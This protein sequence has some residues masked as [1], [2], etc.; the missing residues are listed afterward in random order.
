MKL[1]LALLLLGSSTL[2]ADTQTLSVSYR[3]HAYRFSMV[4]AKVELISDLVK[5]RL[6]LGTCPVRK[7]FAD[8]WK[9]FEEREQAV[10]LLDLPRERDEIVAYDNKKKKGKVLPETDLGRML[11]ELPS[12]FHALAIVARMSCKRI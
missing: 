5:E 7:D 6:Q 3:G 2:F 9:E 1:L 4:G 11:R 12:R 8:L 10:T